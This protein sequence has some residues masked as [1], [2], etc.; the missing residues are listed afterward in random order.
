MASA[1][2]L[3]LGARALPE[4]DVVGIL[5]GQHALIHELIADVETA[6]R[7]HRDTAVT[8]LDHSLRLLLHVER[9]VV[10]PVMSWLAGRSAADVCDEQ[11]L[12]VIRALTE[13]TG[14][15]AGD[16]F[17]E[18]LE[19]LR[20]AVEGHFDCEEQRVLPRI[21]GVCSTGERRHLGDE[22][23]RVQV[24]GARDAFD[25]PLDRVA[26]PMHTLL[27]RMQTPRSL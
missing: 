4:G 2:E 22:V 13:L 25:G 14:P 1:I 26:T 3:R 19:T 23:L 12:Q 5:L 16:G 8:E 20:A 24:A 6:P 27:A 17:A 21:L 10:H 11:R 7:S 9:E 18:R 15:A